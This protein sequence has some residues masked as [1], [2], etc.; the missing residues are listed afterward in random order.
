MSVIIAT[1]TLDH[2]IKR[3][4]F[5][6]LLAHKEVAHCSLVVPN[7]IAFGSD[8]LVYVTDNDRDRVWSK[9]GTFKR[10]F[11]TKCPQTCIAATSDS[12]LLITSLH[13]NTVMVYALEGELIH[14]FGVE[15]SQPGRFDG[16]WG[17]CIETVDW[18]ILL[19]LCE[20]MSTSVLSYSFQLNHILV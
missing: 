7:D 15:G 18:Y 8:I 4:S 20:Q 16:S 6:L 9:E 5:S 14:Q 19:R 17:T 2:M 13:S 10:D 12:D 3:E 1:T 11:K